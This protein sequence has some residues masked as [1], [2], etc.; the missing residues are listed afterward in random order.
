MDRSLPPLRLLAVFE[1]F[2]RTGSVQRAAADLNVTQP[3]IS[4]SLRL[5][6][7]HLGTVLLD[8]RSRPAGLTAAG[9][10]L[11]GGVDEGMGRIAR[12]LA[13]VREAG[14]RRDNAV[15]IACTLGTAT[16]WL[17]P[18][19][20]AFYEAHPAIAVNVQTTAGL[21]GF[22]HG[23]DLVIRYGH[24]RWPDGISTRLFA[25]WVRPVCSPAARARL[26]AAGDLA[27]TLA[28]TLASAPLL[29]VESEDS[30]WL[31]WPQYLGQH[32][33]A[34]AGN[35]PERRF[36]NYVLATQAALAGQG[37]LLGWESNAGDLIREGRLEELGAP[38]CH[39]AEAF[40][41]TLPVGGL[42]PAGEAFRDWLV[43]QF[44]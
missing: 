36:P 13:D 1:A 17:M 16:Y 2:V 24:G 9:E 42:S 20:A 23:V 18:R 8:R 38:P 30:S 22:Q 33:F 43:G 27:A 41:L 5:L 39:P 14:R 26:L 44:G 19:L 31:T 40:F 11:R 7:A 29:H 6:E 35:A 12:A 32:G 3:A 15:T 34:R 28:T 4:Q 10:I 37:L 21:P 25:D